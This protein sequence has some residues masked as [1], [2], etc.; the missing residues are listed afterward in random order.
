MIKKND[1]TMK[2]SRS[3]AIFQFLENF[4]S[5][6]STNDKNMIKKM[7][8]LEKKFQFSMFCRIFAPLEAKMMKNDKN[9]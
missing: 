4:C 7:Q 5:T 1:K 6:G 3:I 8:K 9:K 2:K